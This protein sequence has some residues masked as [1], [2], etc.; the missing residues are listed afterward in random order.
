MK[1]LRY[2]PSFRGPDHDRWRVVIEKLRALGIDEA[3]SVVLGVTHDD[4]PVEE[5]IS[6]E[7]K[8]GV[9]SVESKGTRIRTVDDLFAE[10]G[11]DRESVVI[12]RERVNKW[13]SFYRNAERTGHTV[14]ELYQVRVEFGPS[15]LRVDKFLEEVGRRAEEII[16]GH[17]RGPRVGVRSSGIL[18]EPMLTDMHI[19]KICWDGDELVW[20]KDKAIETYERIIGDMVAEVGHKD[21]GRILLPVGNDLINIDNRGNAT[22][23]GTPQM[24]A[25]IYERIIADTEEMLFRVVDMLQRYAD[26]TV[27]MV[28]GNHDRSSV[29][30]IGRTLGA[31]VRNNGRV[32]IINGHRPRQYF[33]W[34]KVMIGL[35][36]GDQGS[37]DKLPFVASTEQ[38]EMWG[39][40]VCREFHVGHLH[41]SR[42]KTFDTMRHKGMTVRVCPTVSPVDRWHSDMQ[43]VG[44]DE[45]VMCMYFSDDR[46]E[47][48]SY[49]K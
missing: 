5:K 44:Q 35:C 2:S 42:A 25:D 39:S 43:Y 45:N 17:V 49:H 40:T 37:I 18:M 47:G 23:R 48:I 14:V 3:E 1:E 9:V 30:H 7:E 21:I 28:P 32:S 13:D 46:I 38:P 34:K 12:Y 6:S 20:D 31:F 36:H 41:H 29:Y 27:V 16:G 22:F 19:G 11:I 8:G 33:Q 10:L 15:L 26:I 4:V 24:T